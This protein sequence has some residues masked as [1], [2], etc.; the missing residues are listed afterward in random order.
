MY[1]VKS[2][3]TCFAIKSYKETSKHKLS[4]ELSHLSKLH[5]PNIIHCY[6]KLDDTSLLLEYCHCTLESAL[7]KQPV[8]VHKFKHQIALGIA[9]ALQHVHSFNMVHRDIA[10]KNILLTSDYVPK[11][12]D[13]EASLL[14]MPVGTQG[15]NVGVCCICS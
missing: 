9:R 11:L 1:K 6:G 2:H 5:H 10:P 14:L 13:F 8:M 3:G 4:I 7:E 12:I 15:M